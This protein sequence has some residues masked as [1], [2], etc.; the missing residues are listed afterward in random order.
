MRSL[1]LETRCWIRKGTG[2]EAVLVKAADLRFRNSAGEIAARFFFKLFYDGSPVLCGG[3]KFDS[4]GAG[5]RRP[6]SEV[7]SSGFDQLRSN[8][9]APRA[10]RKDFCMRFRSPLKTSRV[11]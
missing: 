4:H 2:L 6:N 10:R 8:R 1:R 9:E 5:P 3:P 7:R 11:V